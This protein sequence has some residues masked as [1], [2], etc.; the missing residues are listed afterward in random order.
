MTVVEEVLLELECLQ[1]VLALLVLEE[2]TLS[3][4]TRALVQLVDIMAMTLRST[5]TQDS[6]DKI[7]QLNSGDTI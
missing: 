2:D 6:L 4:L 5:T 7:E 3:P 1:E